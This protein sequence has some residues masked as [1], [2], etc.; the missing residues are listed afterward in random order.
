MQHRSESPRKRAPVA[1]LALLALGLPS[2]APAQSAD[3]GWVFTVTPYLWLPTIN[4][5]MKYSLPDFSNQAEVETGPNDYLSNL[6]FALMVSGEARKGG[7]S[8]FT[9]VIY[10]DFSSENSRIK[11]FGGVLVDPSL[12]L[13]TQSGLSG[14][15]WTLVGGYAALQSPAATLDVIGGFRTLALKAEV[16]WQLAG[17]IIA[18][19]ET[20]LSTGSASQSV[21]VWD[22]I[23]GVRGRVR[24]GSSRWSMPYYADIGGSGS[25]E[26]WQVMAGVAHS[27]DWG[28]VGLVYRHLAYDLGDAQLLQDAEFSGPA[29]GAS[30]SF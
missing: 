24:L 13:G 15:V 14:G 23:V 5:T 9:D 2:A 20:L 1:L 30:F 17:A 28:N 26:T 6:D 22:A 3:A 12:D 4:G 7:W 11:S 16:D 8:V 25:R 29:L 18:G 21:R 10:L 19:S 27:W